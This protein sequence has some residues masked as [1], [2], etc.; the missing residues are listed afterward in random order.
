MSEKVVGFLPVIP[1]PV[2][3]HQT[4]YTALKNLQDI[5]KQLSQAHLAVTC[6]EGVYH[7]ARETTIGNPVEFENIVLCLGTFHMTKIFIGCIGKYLRNSGA[8]N[9]WIENSVFGPNVVQS[10]LGGTHYVRAFKGMVLLCETMERLQWMSF[11]KGKKPD[12]YKEE[13]PTLV[14]LQDSIARKEVTRSRELLEEFHNSSAKMMESFRNF[15]SDGCSL[16]LSE[17]FHYWRIFITLVSRLR[18]L[19]RADREGNW[20]LHLST[21]QSILPF[22]ALFDCVN[23]LRWCSLYLEDKRSLP[24]AAQAKST[25]SCP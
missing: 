1:S 13:L 4:L 12:T 11:F 15:K 22:F 20:N 10:V 17:T 6:D 21:V 24:E 2:T 8:E 3:D 25:R 14:K 18:N 23:Y 16:K 7:I 19:V 9:I 5:L